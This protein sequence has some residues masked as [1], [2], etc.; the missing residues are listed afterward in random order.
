MNPLANT[1]P[2]RSTANRS[3]ERGIA[4]LRAFRPGSTLLG[5]GELAEKTGLSRSTVTRLT[6]TLVGCGA[7]ELDARTRLYR[8]GPLMLSLGSAMRSG[9]VVVAKG[10]PLMQ[11][12]AQKHRVNVGLAVPDRDEMVYLE[13]LRAHRSI[14]P[15]N[16]VA[17]QR[18][19]TELTSLG[20]AYL[21]T[22]QP[23]QRDAL[24]AAFA[25]RHPRKWASLRAEIE[26]S[27]ASVHQHGYCA[28]SWQPAVLAISTPVPL[29][30]LPPHVLNVSL[31]TSHPMAES[32]DELARHLLALSED[33][34]RAVLLG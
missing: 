24:Y 11:R 18:V 29:E 34:T 3:L 9:S 27:I 30:N 13:S 21:A 26:Q 7:L 19:P 16:V 1:K 23:E 25:R 32:V 20:R 12:V 4:I 15:R 14:S 6:Q 31:T 5:N 8:L 2:G 17:G 28:V 22:A 33:I 10:V